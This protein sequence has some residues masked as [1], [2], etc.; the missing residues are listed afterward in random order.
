MKKTI[1]ISVG[2]S[3][4]APKEI[5]LRFIKEFRRFI[6]SIK[7]AQF[8]LVT[9]GGHVAR[10][11]QE[12]AKQLGAKDKL[13]LDWVGIMATRLNAELLRVCFGKN[14][15]DKVIYNP[16]TY[17]N[18]NHNTNNT[19]KNKTNK[20]INKFKILIA[21]GYLPGCSTDYDAVLLAKTYKADMLINLF[22]QDYVF[23]KDPRKY[24]DAT[25]YPALTWSSYLKMTGEEWKPGLH[26]PFDPIAAKSAKKMKL[27]VILANGNNLNNLKNIVT[28]NKF[29][30]T[31]LQ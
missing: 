20:K 26:V 7:N 15:H 14:A 1:V 2:G 6:L 17:Y 23:D 9:G 21:A 27:K 5:D 10:D 3:L 24:P 28:G 13:S 22:N 31:V 8:I 29:I 11:Y 25:P 4:L 30:G 16:N 19:N 12:S 18:I